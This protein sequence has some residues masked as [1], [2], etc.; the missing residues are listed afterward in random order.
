M[1]E[2]R[3]PW[4][5]NCEQ[6]D[7]EIANFIFAPRVSKGSNQAARYSS[8]PLPPHP[9]LFLFFFFIQ[10]TNRTTGRERVILAIDAIRNWKVFSAG[11][12]RIAVKN[13]A[14]E[15]GN[16][17]RE[18]NI[19]L[20]L[21]KKIGN[22]RWWPTYVMV[23]VGGG[24]LIFMVFENKMGFLG[25]NINDNYG[26]L[27]AAGCGPAALTIVNRR[28]ELSGYELRFPAT[29]HPQGCIISRWKI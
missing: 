22:T 14:G 28:R 8:N 25:G 19:S 12:G 27:L 3:N 9:F 23:V 20:W 17:G 24:R 1:E 26:P 16:F 2:R 6:L 15:A 7:F 29:C 10:L 21:V 13:S 18:S 4:K 11:N 5:E